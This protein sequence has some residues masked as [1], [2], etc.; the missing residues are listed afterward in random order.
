MTGQNRQKKKKQNKKHVRLKRHRHSH[1]QES[2]KHTKLEAMIYTQWICKTK[3]NKITNCKNRNEID[4]QVS[5]IN[6]MR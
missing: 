2:H 3:I 6:V 1:T 5:L 4:K